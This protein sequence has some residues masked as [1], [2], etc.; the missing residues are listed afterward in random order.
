MW[1]NKNMKYKIYL[2][3]VSLAVISF[4]S[5]GD[6]D[7]PTE[8]YFSQGYMK[9]NL[10]G[11]NFDSTHLYNEFFKF[12]QCRYDEWL[13]YL[14][15]YQIGTDE[16]LYFTLISSDFQSGSI[17]KIWFNIENETTQP[18]Y[19]NCYLNFNAKKDDKLISFEIVDPYNP[20]SEVVTISDFTFDPKTYHVT[21]KYECTTSQ[22]NFYRKAI[23]TGEFDLRIKQLV[24]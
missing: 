3:V 20:F 11:S 5:C 1:L 8:E 22:N 17:I 9:G 12:S 7:L 24:E 14:S 16:K 21:G 6:E 15:Y 23:I 4:A 18:K 13:S 10:I 19:A 2:I